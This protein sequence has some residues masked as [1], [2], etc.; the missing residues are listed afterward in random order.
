MK[1]L[2]ILFL[3]LTELFSFSSF[4]N[5][6]PSYSRT[7]ENPRVS[8]EGKEY[9][10]VKAR[11][12]NGSESSLTFYRSADIF[13]FMNGFVKSSQK[14]AANNQD[15]PYAI[16]QLNEFQQLD[17]QTIPF[18]WNKYGVVVYTEITCEKPL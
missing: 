17:I 4:G 15:G 11:Q 1:S 16:L 9:K 8:H 3:V 18:V 5:D 6:L 13:C 7:F 10:V 14:S 12:E 2:A